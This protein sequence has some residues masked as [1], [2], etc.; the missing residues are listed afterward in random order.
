MKIL[1][2]S[3]LY[4]PQHIGGY[5]LGC[6]DVVDRLRLRGHNVQIITSDYRRTNREA[7]PP[8]PTIERVLHLRMD[9]SESPF[10]HW[11]EC[12]KFNRALRRYAPDLVYFWN[13]GGLSHWLPL[14]ARWHDKRMVFF[15][16]DTNFSSWRVGAWLNKAGFFKRLF[17]RS[18]LVHGFSVVQ[19]QPCQFA[20]NFLR[21]FA[22]EQD[23]Q[24]DREHSTVAH[25]GVDGAR[26][27]AGVA[28]NRWPV[29]RLLFSGQIIPQ[30][31][32]GTAIRA[33]ADL[34]REEPFRHLQF[35]IVGGA[36]F[37]DH[38]EELKVLARELSVDDRVHFLGRVERN[39][40]PEIFA[41]HDVLIFPSEWQ[42]PF[43]ITPLEA[44]AAGMAVVGTTTGGSGE[45]FIDRH[46]AMTF[47]AGDAVDCTRALRELLTDESLFHKIRETGHR[48]VLER[49]S[50]EVMVD[51]LE[52][53][54]LQLRRSS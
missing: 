32:I 36:A 33:F 26:F 10:N 43:A 44:M 13:L 3:N 16:S 40:L 12:R 54:L 21:Q 30:K 49:H 31:G 17:P 9:A 20:S 46:N 8:D 25:W 27:S 52:Q 47:R 18:L 37:P 14:A 24:P 4:P 35:S 39:L 15:L 1:V 41:A 42:E 5:E 29:E 2:V 45:L 51:S 7:P 48:E 22:L 28:R 11:T 23:I 6:R 34:V 53:N 19:G 38:L 50:L